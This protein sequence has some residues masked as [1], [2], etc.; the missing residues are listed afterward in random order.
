MPSTYR[1]DIYGP[2]DGSAGSGVRVRRRP[3]PLQSGGDVQ[4]GPWIYGGSSWKLDCGDTITRN[5]SYMLLRPGHYACL[6]CS[7]MAAALLDGWR[8]STAIFTEDRRADCGHT[9]AGGERWAVRDSGHDDAGHTMRCLDCAS[10]L[11]A[12]KPAEPVKLLTGWRLSIIHIGKADLNGKRVHLSCG[13]KIG[14]DEH[15][16]IREVG[17]KNDT[18]RCIPCASKSAEPTKP[19]P[20]P[21]A[22]GRCA[23]ARVPH[24]V[25]GTMV[26]WQKGSPDATAADVTRMKATIEVEVLR[27]GRERI[28]GWK[29]PT[30]SK[31]GLPLNLQV[32]YTP[33]GPPCAVLTCDHCRP[34]PV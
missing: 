4:N 6:A 3:D 5:R 33:G 21:K 24:V 7:S 28:G 31:T 8:L 13:H 11:P 32:Q 16:A 15:W 17:K 9:I 29:W 20:E 12:A 14:D 25:A 30:C 19:A 10:T 23:H 22:D 34:K 26:P 1:S 27:L 18:H 2:A